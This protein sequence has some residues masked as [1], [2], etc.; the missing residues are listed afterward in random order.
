[1]SDEQQ[2]YA[3]SQ[4]A[5]RTPTTGAAV[6]SRRRM[7]R[8]RKIWY[9]LLAALA[10]FLMR[11]IWLTC[12]VERVIGAEQLRQLK[13]ASHQMRRPLCLCPFE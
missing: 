9:W 12:R 5:Q 6:S 3:P 1:M 4:K 10:K 11:L 7:S 2:P 8:G 13:Q